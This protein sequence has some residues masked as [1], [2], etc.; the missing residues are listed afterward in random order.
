MD[1][2]E[3]HV[4]ALLNFC[5]KWRIV[6]NMKQNCLPAIVGVNWN[7]KRKHYISCSLSVST[8]EWISH[9]TQITIC[10]D[11]P[12]WC[13]QVLWVKL[14]FLYRYPSANHLVTEK[15][16]LS[17]CMRKNTENSRMLIRVLRNISFAKKNQRDA[18]A[19]LYYELW[20][21]KI[22]ECI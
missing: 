4:Y 8:I 1:W 17:Q 12:I 20:Q 21:P 15:K 5:H 3:V 9:C 7:S 22:P 18:T 11:R 16:N 14:D 6:C 13:N 19:S 10:T 2:T